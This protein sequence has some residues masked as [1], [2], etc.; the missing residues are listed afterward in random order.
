MKNILEVCPIFKA[1]FMYIFVL[2]F[3]IYVFNFVG[4][5]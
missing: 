3:Y 2:L 4:Y 5:F 1:T